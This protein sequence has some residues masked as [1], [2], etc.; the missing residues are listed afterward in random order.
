MNIE[1]KHRY[2]GSILFAGEF[3][4][5]QLAAKAAVSAKAKL[6]DAD[7]RGADLYGANLRG[8]ELSCADLYG[9][10]LRGATLRGATLS[11]ANLRGA[12][13]RGATLSGADLR[14][15]NLYDA[16]LYYANLRG[17]DTQHCAR[18][19]SASLGHYALYCYA[20]PDGLRYTAGCRR[21][22]TLAEARAHWAPNRVD[23]WT[24]HEPEY[25]AQ[26]LRAVEFLRAEA[27]ALCWVE[28]ET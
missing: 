19:I 12:D 15:A 14:G 25:G 24:V 18:I 13:L 28:D 16:D 23:F 1:I 9:A 4:S 22:L 11:G 6:Y 20:E 7:L 3:G 5:L 27:V 26:M 21:S 17:A 10:N 8:A 2:S